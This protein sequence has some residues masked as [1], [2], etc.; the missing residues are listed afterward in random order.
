MKK[1]Y[2]VSEKEIRKYLSYELN[3]IPIIVYEKTDSTNLRAKIKLKEECLNSFLIVASSQSAGRGRGEK[4]FFSKGH[5]S[6]YECIAAT[7]I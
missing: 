4:S 7:A 1:E 3:K 2:T 6:L 5:A